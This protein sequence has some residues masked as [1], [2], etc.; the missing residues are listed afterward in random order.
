MIQEKSD[1]ITSEPLSGLVNLTLLG[2]HPNHQNP[3]LKLN[4]QYKCINI[5]CCPI[6]LIHCTSLIRNFSENKLSASFFS[7]KNLEI[8]QFQICI[9]VICE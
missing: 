3:D 5:F 6:S 4:F 2:S 7:V 8:S 1:H 9:L